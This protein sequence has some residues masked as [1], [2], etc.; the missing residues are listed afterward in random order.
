[1]TEIITKGR[2]VKISGLP[3]IRVPKGKIALMRNFHLIEYQDTNT[4]EVAKYGTISFVSI[5]EYEYNGS[6]YP[7]IDIRYCNFEYNKEKL[8]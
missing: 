4:Y 7:L 2:T 6:K 3:I 8:R 1:M 5:E